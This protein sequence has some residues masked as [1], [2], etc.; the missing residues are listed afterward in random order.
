MKSLVATQGSEVFCD[1]LAVAEKFGIQHIRVLTIIDNLK[2][3]YLKIK[4]CTSA[5]LNFKEQIRSYRGKTFKVFI[6][7][8]RTF[9]LLAM[10]F[11]GKKALEWQ[12]KFNDAFYLM[13]KQLLLEV[14]NKN[15]EQWI[16]QREQGKLARKTETDILKEF[17]E[18]ATAQGSSKAQFYY[19][20][21]TLATYK[22][23]NMIEAEKPKL[24]DTL[25]I[26]ELSQL[27]MA[28]HI[29]EMSIKKH[30]AAKE[31]YKAIYSLVKIDLDKFADAMM[32]GHNLQIT[33]KGGK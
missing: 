4:G 3:E 13:E 31:H 18:Y 17:V 11:K 2:E 12:S 29:A 5:P 22:C 16:K 30:M 20:H 32:I 15:N 14:N 9:S 26:M 27:M 33:N 10:R 21:F 6:M 7:D 25:N 24:R 28:E 19:K 1:S 23:L 8:R